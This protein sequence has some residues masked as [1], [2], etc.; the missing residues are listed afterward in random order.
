MRPPAALLGGTA[1][2]KP[3]GGFQLNACGRAAG[4]YR[5]GYPLPLQGRAM[6]A[7]PPVEGAHG[8]SACRPAACLA[9]L[10]RL[11]V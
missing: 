10:S 8:P 7:L 2:K 6:R 9:A 3:R 11:R 5:G 4:R 1:E